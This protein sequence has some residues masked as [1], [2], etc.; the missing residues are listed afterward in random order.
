MRGGKLCTKTAISLT[1]EFTL[2][3]PGPPSTVC[4]ASRK[5]AF[6]G[7]LFNY[8]LVLEIGVFLEN[9]ASNDCSSCSRHVFFQKNAGERTGQDLSPESMRSWRCLPCEP[10]QYSF[11]HWSHQKNV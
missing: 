3:S 8:L 4:P 7:R 6:S 1:R 2:S 10:F 11:P 5:R 9:P